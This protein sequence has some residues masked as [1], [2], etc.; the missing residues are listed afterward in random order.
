[1]NHER[2]YVDDPEL[3]PTI[4]SAEFVMPPRSL[5][6]TLNQGL[7]L[8]DEMQRDRFLFDA[9]GFSIGV[10][11]HGQINAAVHGR[12]SHGNQIAVTMCR[13]DQCRKL[14]QWLLAIAAL[15]D[16]EIAPSGITL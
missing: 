4:D 16:D 2:I 10:N 3:L 12:D 7:G 1:M 13:R 5:Y 6:R 8:D 15:D 11:H 9:D 14:G